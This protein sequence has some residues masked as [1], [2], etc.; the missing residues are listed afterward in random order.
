[1]LILGL[2]QNKN[3]KTNLVERI[4]IYL[5]ISV[6][7]VGVLGFDMLNQKMTRK[8]ESKDFTSSSHTQFSRIK[9]P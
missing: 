4:E 3:L 1:M 7:G 5:R 8:N 2:S 6:S 9:A